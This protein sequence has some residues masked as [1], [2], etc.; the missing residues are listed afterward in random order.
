MCGTSGYTSGSAIALTYCPDQNREAD[1]KDNN[2]ALVL[3]LVAR[4]GGAKLVFVSEQGALLFPHM[5][6]RPRDC[7]VS[8]GAVR[9]GP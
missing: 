2:A 3:L 7:T 4:R 5:Y 9:C 1:N 8:L 6:I